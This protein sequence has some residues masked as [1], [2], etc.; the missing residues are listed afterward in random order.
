MRNLDKVQLFGFHEATVSATPD[1]L[2]GL[3]STAVNDVVPVVE[4]HKVIEAPKLYATTVP[5]KGGPV[6]ILEYDHSP[7]GHRQLANLIRGE[8]VI[9]VV[10]GHRVNIETASVIEMQIGDAEVVDRIPTQ[11]Q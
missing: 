10:L 4:S 9:G 8:R 6:K 1:L 2:A 5:I 3:V 11:E 7:E